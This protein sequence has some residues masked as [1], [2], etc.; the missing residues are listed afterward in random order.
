MDPQIDGTYGTPAWGAITYRPE[1][2]RALARGDGLGLHVHPYRR[3][4]GPPRWLADFGDQAWVD[5]CLDLGL[6][7]FQAAWGRP[8]AAFRFGDGWLN[9]ATVARLEASGVRHDLT[10]EPGAHLP[11]GLRRG[12]ARRGLGPDLRALPR[13]PYRPSL[14]DFRRP[15]PARTA[16]L[17]LIPVT[18]GRLR[19][20]LALVRRLYRGIRRPG[21]VTPAHLVLNPA[22]SP[23]L[24]R[25]LLDR[26]LASGARPLVL[27][28]RSE[29]GLSP[30]RLANITRNLETL[31]S[32]RRGAELALCTPSEALTALGL[33]APSGDPMAGSVAAE[34]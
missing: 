12:A 28:V 19:P 25:D 17:W 7:A 8:C 29:A 10:L 33:E 30:R 5:R 15:D 21:W 23:L 26:A 24:F 2:D 34:G 1:L 11:H 31:G 16:G 32:W 22:L 18:T 20:S 13:E 14:T 9:D 4:E 27:T 3:Q 6:T